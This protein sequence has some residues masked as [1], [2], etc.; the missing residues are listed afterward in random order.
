[1]LLRMLIKPTVFLIIL[2][3]PCAAVTLAQDE[4]N[5]WQRVITGAGFNIDVSVESLKLE[6][7]R[8]LAAKFKTTLSKSEP[9]DEKSGQKYKTRIETI[10]FNSNSDEYRIAETDFLDSSGK[11]ITSSS[12]A[13][14][15]PIRGVTASTLYER[16]KSL[17]PFGSWKVKTYHFADGKS[18]AID[19]PPDLKKL[20]G[21]SLS[22]SFDN[23]QL[24]GKSCARPSF[25]LK[26]ISD[27]EFTKRV[28]S[29]L[30]T[31]G[32]EASSLDAI[33]M[34]CDPDRSHV[35]QTFFLQLSK[36]K[37]LLFWDGVFVDLERPDRNLGAS[38]LKLITN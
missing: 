30:K 23:V 21:A 26:K 38:L 37:I 13:K 36:Q 29:P 18:A 2:L 33:L 9:I 4:N 34:K 35:P 5:T 3:G 27:A 17:P 14:W 10:E 12:S 31:L 19:D 22:F 11:L 32:V 25:E 1:M 28:G 24:A 16:A 20:I 7:N 15:K 8:N 6:A